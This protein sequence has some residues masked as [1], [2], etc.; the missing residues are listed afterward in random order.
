MKR[1]KL[2]TISVHAAL[3][4]VTNAQKEQDAERLF[5]FIYDAIPVGTLDL[6]MLKLASAYMHDFYG[7]AVQEAA[8]KFHDV[9]QER[10]RRFKER[11]KAG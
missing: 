2:A 6:L 5:K 7:A 1:K 9:L 4:E 3:T 10:E 8:A 11:R